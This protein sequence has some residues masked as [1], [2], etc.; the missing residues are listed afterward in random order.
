MDV[1]RAALSINL[2]SAAVVLAAVLG[3]RTAEMPTIHSLTIHGLRALKPA[4]VKT[5]REFIV[6]EA[7]KFTCISLL[8]LYPTIAYLSTTATATLHITTTINSACPKCVKKSGKFSCC[9]RGGAWFNKCGKPGDPKFDHTWT[10]GIEACRGVI[11][12]SE[13]DLCDRSNGELA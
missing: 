13:V 1:L 3:S 12:T 4:K 7:K 9:F 5:A 11:V 6:W 8:S 10:E 2:A